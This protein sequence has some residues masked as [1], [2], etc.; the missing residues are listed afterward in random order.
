MRDKSVS[1][2]VGRP[3]DRLNV[4]IILSIFT[5]PMT[6]GLL[7]PFLG[8][9]SRTFSLDYRQAGLIFTFFSTGYLVSALCIGAITDKHGIRT[10]I[11][12]LLINAA[13][14]LMI[15]AVRSFA[16]FL[17]AMVILGVSLGIEDIL[18]ATSLTQL[19]PEKKGFYLNIMQF[20][21]CMAG[22]LL[23][24]MAGVLVQ[25]GISWRFAYVLSFAFAIILFVF[26][27]R[28]SF[29]PN[30][31]PPDPARKA[32]A[33]LVP[34]MRI[35]LLCLLF[36]SIFAIESGIFGWLGLYMT[37][38]FHVS[39]FLSGLSISL[40]YLAMG[41]GRLL[42][43]FIS[44][45]VRHTRLILCSG[46]VSTVFLVSALA[47][48]NAVVSLTFFVLTMFASAS[49]FTTAIS[50]AGTLYPERTGAVLSVL[51]STGTMGSILMPGLIGTIAQAAGLKTGLS[52][53]IY[54]C[55][56]VIITTAMLANILH[57]RSRTGL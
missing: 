29:P 31:F 55:V 14:A 53:L 1:A 20:A 23:S 34:D 8:V 36:F 25:N 37:G 43:A 48:D 40:L 18:S 42:A 45:R 26:L 47:A 50:F 54:L 11:W 33:P 13:A 35:I 12:G 17:A 41:F 5:Y 3:G 51:F 27:R 7:S 32:S 4:L 57:R 15:F 9:I 39:G 49:L 6:F 28:E 22:I 56:V 52:V 30:P 2:S 16:L 21:G 24:I 38:R 44:D 46:A 19:N 10:I